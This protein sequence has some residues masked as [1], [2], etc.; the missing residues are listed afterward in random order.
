[1]C[2]YVCVCVCV[3]VSVQTGHRNGS[4]FVCVCVCVCTE[5]WHRNRVTSQKIIGQIHFLV[6]L[7]RCLSDRCSY[8]SLPDGQS[9][10]Q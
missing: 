2:V 9:Q 1:M 6:K 10:R 3:C 5:T 8:E 4:F 7:E